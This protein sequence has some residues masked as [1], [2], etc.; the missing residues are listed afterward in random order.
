MIT[1]LLEH[2]VPFKTLQ[3]ETACTIPLFLT[4]DE[5]K[6]MRRK[7]RMD[8]L[9]EIQDKQKLGL[10]EP[11]PPKVKLSNMM[12]VFTNQAVSDPSKLEQ[13]VRNQIKARLEKHLEANQKRKLTKD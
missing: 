13:E 5:K 2:P 12:K 11:P 6:R 9:K 10:V 3:Q 4:R 8:R 7:K 1:H